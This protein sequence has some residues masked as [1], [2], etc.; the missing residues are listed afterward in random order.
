MP[1]NTSG[2]DGTGVSFY[3]DG[4]TDM[5]LIRLTGEVGRVTLLGCPSPAE[6]FRVMSAE[7]AG[8]L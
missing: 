8:S 6:S 5:A 4:R 3:P 1:N 7:E 2:F